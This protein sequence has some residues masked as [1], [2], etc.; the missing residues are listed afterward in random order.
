MTRNTTHQLSGSSTLDFKLDVISANTG[1][2]HYG[3]ETVDYTYLLDDRGIIKLTTTQAYGNFDKETISR[4]VQMEA[5]RI[6]K[7][8]V[9]T[10]AYKTKNQ[11]RFYGSDGTGLIMTVAQG[12]TATSSIANSSSAGSEEHRYT[13]FSYPFT[14]TCAWS[15]EDD[16]GDDVIY[17]G[18]SDGWVYQANKG[19][20]FD[21]AEIESN[22]VLAFNNN[23]S[24]NYLKQYRKL[25]LEMTSYGYSEVGLHPEFSYGNPFTSTHIQQLFDIKGVGGFWNV[26]TW[27]TIYYYDSQLVYQPE[28]QIAG[29]GTNISLVLHAKSAIDLGHKFDGVIFQYTTR[30]LVR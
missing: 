28:L 1:C 7:L 30:R 24:P 25:L 22:L 26:S 4:K 23:K 15:G 29:E 2:I 18:S 6:K 9:C 19:S 11:I 21:G 17:L 27:N 12:G 8:L 5:N 10:T 16:T 20:S 3:A 14:V 13:E